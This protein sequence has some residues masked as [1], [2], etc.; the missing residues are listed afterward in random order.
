MH[1]AA[2]LGVG[3]KSTKHALDVDAVM[4]VEAT[5]FG[6]QRGFDEVVGHFV[7]RHQFGVL[8]AAATDDVAVTVEKSDREVGLF[9][10][11]VVGGLTKGGKGERQHE[12]QTAG[13][14]RRHFRQRLDEQPAAP[15][16]DMG[17]VH[18]GREALVDF[19]GPFAALEH[20]KIDPGVDI[21]QQPFEPRP[22][23]VAR[24]GKHVGHFSALREGT[25]T[26]GPAPLVFVADG[27]FAGQP[28]VIPPGDRWFS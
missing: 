8:D 26:F 4:V 9:Q 7:K 11:V 28:L 6:R 25:S 21:E 24:I 14:Q 22:P 1:D 5:I 2:G 27:D 19:T 18:E 16:R 23:I 13:S 10:P 17:A 15:A 20:G 12:N 3:D